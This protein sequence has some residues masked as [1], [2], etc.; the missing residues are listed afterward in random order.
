MPRRDFLSIETK[1][2]WT[3]II[4]FTKEFVTTAETFDLLF[5]FSEIILQ[6]IG[7]KKVEVGKIIYIKRIRTSI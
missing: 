7:M 4:T 3:K 2:F 6:I 1:T 5:G